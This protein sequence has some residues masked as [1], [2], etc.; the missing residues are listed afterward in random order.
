MSE[1]AGD[2]YRVYR[3]L[4]S[5]IRSWAWTKMAVWTTTN[6]YRNSVIQFDHTVHLR[7]RMAKLFTTSMCYRNSDDD[8]GE[9]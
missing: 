3:H 6:V 1:T 2:S 5:E 9:N 7:C 4:F 8:T